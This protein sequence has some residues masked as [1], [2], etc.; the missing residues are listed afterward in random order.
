MGLS[1]MTRS[2]KAP[3][4]GGSAKSSEDP[5]LSPAAAE[6]ASLTTAWQLGPT[7]DF[8]AND[9][10]GGGDGERSLASAA[11]SLVFLERCGHFIL[12]SIYQKCNLLE[13]KAVKLAQDY[14]WIEFVEYSYI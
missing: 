9:A 3:P 8:N 14:Q 6:R 11:A 1:M 10:R 13:L 12:F 5:L 4:G 7:A 2:E